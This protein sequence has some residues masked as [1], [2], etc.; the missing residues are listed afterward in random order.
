MKILEKLAKA[1]RVHWYRVV[2]KSDSEDVLRAL[3]FEEIGRIWCQQS[4]VTWRRHVVKHAE[5]SRLKKRTQKRTHR[6][7]ARCC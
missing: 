3:D 5:D 7:V 4:K 2:L 1:N 6:E